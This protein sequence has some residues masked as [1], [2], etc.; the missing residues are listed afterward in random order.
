M[1]EFDLDLLRAERVGLDEALFCAGKTDGQIVRIVE[2]FS[3]NARSGT[4]TTA[5]W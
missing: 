2:C 3:H 5:H 4:Q 1:N